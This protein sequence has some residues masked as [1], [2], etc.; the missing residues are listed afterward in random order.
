MCAANPCYVTSS[1]LLCDVIFCFE[2]AAALQFRQEHEMTG[3]RTNLHLFV[4]I[5]V[6]HDLDHLS[7][8]VTGEDSWS[9]S[10][11]WVLMTMMMFIWI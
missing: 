5:D 8:L 7:D 10:F 11:C 2:R 1:Y 3:L 4:N 9:H 6:Y